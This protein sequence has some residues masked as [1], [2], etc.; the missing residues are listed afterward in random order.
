M[1]MTAVLHTHSRR[2]NYHPHVHVVVPGGCLHRKRRQWKKLEGKY[3]F[4]EFALAKVYRARLL[5]ALTS[6]GSS[7][8]AH[9][10][11]KWVVDCEH[12]G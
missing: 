9:L 3:L 4:N 12:V 7:L 6:A 5:E 10:P 2:L 1:G 8:P 11:D